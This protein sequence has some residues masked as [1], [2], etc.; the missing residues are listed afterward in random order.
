VLDTL[1]PD[2]S[3]TAS[4]APG[5]LS[6]R[7]PGAVRPDFF[8]VGGPKCGTTAMSD[9]LAAHPEIFMARKEMHF[10]GKDLR[11]APHFYRRAEPEYLAEFNAWNR[12]RRAGEASVWYLF[13]ET[14][15]AEIHA[16][17]PSA[18]IIILLREP[19]E[20]MHSLFGYFR[21]DGNEPLTSF[22]AA[23]Q[24]EPDRRA[25]RRLGRQTYFPPGLVYRDTARFARQVQRYFDVFGPERVHVVLQEDLAADPAAVYRNTLRFLE[26]D[27]TRGL[28]QFQRVNAAKTVRSRAL[29]SVL[30]DPTVRSAILAVRPML[31]QALFH[32]AHR[33]ERLLQ[34]FNSSNEK[35]PP[36]DPELV[37]VLRRE[38]AP[39]VEQ[40][41]KLIGRDLSHW[42]KTPNSAARN[43]RLGLP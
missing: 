19:V 1:P 20:M 15:A 11:F 39:E 21:F 35:P 36:L 42:S 10:F 32:A 17:N 22:P 14:A 23:L 37:S 13:S 6:V 34:H 3:R 30:N 9:Y 28:P 38:F 7:P 18:R 31:P 41:G 27:S 25:G 4:P 40:L 29:R 2:I 12:Q 5:R 8:I 24:A 43:G 16:F 26:V 33:V